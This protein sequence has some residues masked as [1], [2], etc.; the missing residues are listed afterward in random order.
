MI[1]E[2]IKFKNVLT[3]ILGCMIFSISGCK[4]DGNGGPDEEEPRDLTGF[5]FGADLS[6]V[7]QILDYGGIYKEAS[8]M[9]NP[10][11]IFKDR[12]TKLVRFRLWHNPEWTKDVYDPAGDQMYNDIQDVAR[13]IEL[14][15]AQGLEV[16]LDF[17]YSDSWADP[18]KQT[19]PA[20]W[21][22][23]KSIDVL[24]DSVYNYTF[25]TLKFLD[26]KGLMP[27]FVQIGNETNCGMLST[28]VPSG[29]PAC[30]V[31]NGAWQNAGR[32]INTAID[33]VKDASATSA[34][35]TKTILHVA[36]PKNVEW[37]FDNIKSNGA[38]TNFDVVGFS[39]YPL[40]HTTVSVDQLSDKIS[41]F[42]SKYG[43]QV[44]ILET[45]YPWTTE[46]DDS[47]NNSFG[48]E[49]A[50]TGYPK[51]K[52]GQ[53]DMMIKLTQ[54]VLDGGGQGIIYWEPAWISSPMKDLW[55]TGSSWE[56]CTYFDFDGNAMDVMDYVKHSYK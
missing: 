27:E 7:N 46:A 33:A 54:E 48:S 4:D 50:I 25:K 9:K 40:W 16:L 35:K 38:V 26:G 17:H 19:I 21:L 1:N 53:K 42:K 29:F 22:E 47:Y 44:M 30:N 36:D 10:Y 32:L 6:Y 43:K 45:A 56:N 13:A 39:Y 14:S 49:T 37:W 24:E 55:G 31:C 52:Q 2:V 51:T 3:I 18:G 34:I 20:A 5:Y 23:I 15:K 11:Q 8:V 41:L 12:G 28:S